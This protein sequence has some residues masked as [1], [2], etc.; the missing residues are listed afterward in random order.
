VILAFMTHLLFW[1]QPRSHIFTMGGEGRTAAGDEQR[2]SDVKARSNF[3]FDSLLL[4]S[5]RPGGIGGP[6]ISN[7]VLQQN[8]VWIDP[9]L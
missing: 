1:F 9:V 5:P 3:V 8:I 7:R 6:A 2:F 4:R